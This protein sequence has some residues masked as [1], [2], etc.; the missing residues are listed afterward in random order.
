MHCI[1]K[2]T[3][4]IIVNQGNDYLVKVKGNQ[5]NLLKAIR[6]IIEQTEPKSTF[7]LN[8]RTRGRDEHRLTKIYYPEGYI[9]EGWCSLNRIIHVERHFE[10]KR[11]THQS[12]SYYISSVNSDNAEL[13]AK[14]V[15]G[16]WFIE[17]KLHHVKDVIMRE[18][19]I[20][21][22]SGY[23]PENMSIIRNIAINV[24]KSNNQKS[25]KH[26]SIFFAS[27]VKE[28]LKLLICRT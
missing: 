21:N 9:P 16:H 26:A 18:D 20:K 25:I 24:L 23:A 2:K 4:Q 1:V 10:S 12:D 22:N 7:A 15:R 14:G 8:E 17:N 13:F 11:K 27:N 6:A 28:L 19:Y 3:L 5:P